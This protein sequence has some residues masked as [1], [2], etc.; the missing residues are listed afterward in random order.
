MNSS[1]PPLYPQE[2]YPE[3]NR[4][5]FFQG[6]NDCMGKSTS[7]PSCQQSMGLQS[8]FSGGIGNLILPLLLKTMSGGNSN[9]QDL[10]KSLGGDGENPILSALANFSNKKTPTEDVGEKQFPND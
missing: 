6:Q 3:Q 5:Q 7:C 2:A 4:S 10:F 8:N 9:M 1:F